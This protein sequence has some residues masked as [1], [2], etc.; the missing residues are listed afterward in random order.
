V[1][2]AIIDAQPVT[3]TGF[4]AITV[5]VVCLATAQILVPTVAVVAILAARSVTV[6]TTFSIVK[7]TTTVATAVTAIVYVAF[8]FAVSFVRLL[9]VAPVLRCCLGFGASVTHRV[10]L[11]S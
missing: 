10:T 6:V 11:R 5:A 8:V 7:I 4:R 3:I 2:Y 1:T 9:S